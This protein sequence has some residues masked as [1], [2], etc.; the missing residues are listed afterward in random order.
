MYYD[1]QPT[2]NIY[3]YS[4]YYDILS[5]STS[6][7]ETIISVF[8]D[9]FDTTSSHRIKLF[10]I[11]R[12]LLFFRNLK[13]ILKTYFQDTLYIVIHVKESTYILLVVKIYITSINL[14]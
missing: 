10:E 1:I 9:I 13:N 14:K 7:K 5:S 12:K 4:M 2:V 6:T 11:F 8:L 3:L